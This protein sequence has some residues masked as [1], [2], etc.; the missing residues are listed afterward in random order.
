MSCCGSTIYPQIVGLAGRWVQRLLSVTDCPLWG[1]RRFLRSIFPP[2]SSSTAMEVVAVMVATQEGCTSTSIRMVF[3]MKPAKIM[4]Y[5]VL[6]VHVQLY[7][8]P[9]P[10][11]QQLYMWPQTI[12]CVIQCNSYMY[13]YSNNA[14]L[15]LRQFI[16]CI[17][18]CKWF[19]EFDNIE[20]LMS[21]DQY[22]N[23]DQ[24][25]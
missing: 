24:Q 23:D 15:Y 12:K 14:W 20:A 4:K 18:G 21:E 19:V 11:M 17:Y 8:C 6:N 9:A 22:N 16:T 25:R 5:V 7:V 13:M 1:R 2:K 3:L 10:S